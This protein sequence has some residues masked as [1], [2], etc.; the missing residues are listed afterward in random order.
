MFKKRL[1]A[2]I[3]GVIFSFGFAPFDLWLLSVLSVA[4]LIGLLDKSSNKEAFLVGYAFGF[5]M[6]LS[7]ISWLY[8][9]IH[10]HG[11]VGIIGSS[12]IAVSYTHLTLP[13]KRIV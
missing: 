1:L 3:C 11:N 6:W 7:G 5:G 13:T 9:S 2:L 12:L 10:Y 8:V 4:V